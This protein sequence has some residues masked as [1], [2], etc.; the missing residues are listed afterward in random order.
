MFL[1]KLETSKHEEIKGMSTD[2]LPIK[3]ITSEAFPAHIN[4]KAN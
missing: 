2:N 1:Y 4:N 3:Q